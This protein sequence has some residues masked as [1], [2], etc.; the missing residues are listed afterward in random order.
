MQNC[1]KCCGTCE[2][3]S[4]DENDGYMCVSTESEYTADYTEYE[5][6]CDCWEQKRRKQKWTLH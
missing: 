2:H 1:N 3:A 6:T 4:Y 5:H